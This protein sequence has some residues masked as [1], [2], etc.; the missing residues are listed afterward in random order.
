MSF[1]KKKTFQQHFFY[2]CLIVSTAYFSLYVI[3]M[4]CQKFKP[5]EQHCKHF[6]LK[7]ST[8]QP[9]VPA[10]ISLDK[11]YK[12]KSET[13]RQHRLTVPRIFV[14]DIVSQ[15]FRKHSTGNGKS[16]LFL[17]N[18]EKALLKDFDLFLYS[19]SFFWKIL[20]VFGQDLLENLKCS[21]NIFSSW[22]IVCVLEISLK[23]NGYFSKIGQQLLLPFDI[24]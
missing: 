18:F 19:I 23:K 11:Q 10:G 8:S 21:Y 24:I 1:K 22:K 15:P 3:G 9:S 17:Q 14:R 20:C 5:D 2:K 16:Y 6:S 13:M 7:M 12:T 4:M